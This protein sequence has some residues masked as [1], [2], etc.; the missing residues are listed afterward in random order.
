LP[1]DLDDVHSHYIEAT[2]KGMLIG[3]LYLPN[4]NPVPSPK[5]DYKLR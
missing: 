1:G 5:Y 2:V 3:C 4:G